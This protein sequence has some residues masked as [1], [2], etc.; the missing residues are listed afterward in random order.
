MSFVVNWCSGDN[1]LVAYAA[2]LAASRSKNIPDE[3]VQKAVIEAVK[4]N[5]DNHLVAHGAVALLASVIA[6]RAGLVTSVLESL[7][8]NSTSE[9]VSEEI[10]WRLEFGC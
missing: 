8:V 1:S 4:L 5:A 7:P 2:L 9:I 6:D 3:I 10:K